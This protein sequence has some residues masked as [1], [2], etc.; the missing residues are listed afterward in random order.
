LPDGSLAG[1][2]LFNSV[3]LETNHLA[4]FPELEPHVLKGRPPEEMKSV[5][6]L[7]QV[8]AER[9]ESVVPIRAVVITHVLESSR[10][11]MAHASRGEAL[12]ALGTSSMLQI[13]SPGMRG[14]DKMA[15]LIQQVPCYRL[16]L[17]LDLESI[18]LRAEDIL[19]EVVRS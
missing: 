10:S 14:F 17:G 13:P 2:S 3:F 18:P 1:H 7:S 4:R 8:F 15:H 12:L 16:G 9:L 6:V 11:R 5:I 19:S